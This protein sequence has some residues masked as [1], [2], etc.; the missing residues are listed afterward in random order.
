M[1]SV[2]LIYCLEHQL[3]EMLIGFVKGFIAFI[4]PI[5]SYCSS[6]WSPCLIC[7]IDEIESVQKLFTM[8]IPGLQLQSYKKRLISLNLSSLERRRL[9][10]DLTLCF[11]M[12][13]G[14]TKFDP[15]AFGLKLSESV[16]RG[17]PLKLILDH[18][19]I[20]TR[21]HAFANRVIA[22]WNSLP[23]KC[24]TVNSVAAFKYCIKSKIQ[25]NF[26]NMQMPI[27]F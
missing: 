4:L 15:V 1:P 11:K 10:A 21:K 20:N 26:Y 13:K 14:F 3:L 5:V 8:R 19:R 12:L 7:D 9:W 27:Q 2:Q 23:E 16:T 25:I 6:V 17:H 22:P 18:S 24:V